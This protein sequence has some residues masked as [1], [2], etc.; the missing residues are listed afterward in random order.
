[1]ENFDLRKYLAENKLLKEEII[2]DVEL[3]MGLDAD[4]IEGD[5]LPAGEFLDRFDEF[6]RTTGEEGGDSDF[7][8]Q[9]LENHVDAGVLTNEE[10][11]EVMDMF[12]S[13]VSLGPDMFENKLLKE[14]HMDDFLE[15]V[16]AG[17]GDSKE[18]Y[19]DDWEDMY[20]DTPN[21]RYH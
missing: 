2:L 11:E 8:V 17:S 12:Y 15:T 14:N 18:V 21:L 5:K 1:M 4:K 6:W 7:L 13:D 10:T 16:M 20:F 19:Y 3:M 9:G